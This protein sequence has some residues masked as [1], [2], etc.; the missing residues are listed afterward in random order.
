MKNI[1]FI[2]FIIIAGIISM[3]VSCSNLE[4]VNV[5]NSIKFDV[6]PVVAYARALTET[7]KADALDVVI[8]LKA[9]RK[10]ETK[11]IKVSRD[12]STTVQPVVFSDIDDGETAA[13]TVEVVDKSQTGVVDKVVY[14]KGNGSCVV[15][16]GEEK[17]LDIELSANTKPEIPLPCY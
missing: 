7:D 10:A 16:A 8:T 2:K 1:R 12:Y 15:T 13:V 4:T 11:T 3:F 17:P 9:G 5:N 6:S 14:A